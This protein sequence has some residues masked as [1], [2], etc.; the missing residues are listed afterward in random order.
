MKFSIEIKEEEKTTKYTV[1]TTQTER[2]IEDI[3][4]DGKADEAPPWE[5]ETEIEP[6]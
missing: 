4:I 3:A 6:Y 5:T 2:K 1:D